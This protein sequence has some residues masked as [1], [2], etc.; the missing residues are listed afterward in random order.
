[1]S[2]IC[3]YMTTFS[4]TLEVTQM[5]VVWSNGD[6]GAF[7]R[8]VPLVSRELHRLAKRYMGMENPGQTL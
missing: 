4:I 1:M 8:F 7:N 2:I 5:L 6:Y 3:D